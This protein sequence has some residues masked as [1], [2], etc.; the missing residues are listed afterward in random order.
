MPK[1]EQSKI[2]KELRQ[3]VQSWIS[4]LQKDSLFIIPGSDIGELEYCF[5]QNYL[6]LEDAIGFMINEHQI[7]TK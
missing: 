2:L 6:Y 3:S 5:K 7:E 4:Q 1:H